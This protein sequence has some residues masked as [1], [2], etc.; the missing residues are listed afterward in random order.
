[1]TTGLHNLPAPNGARQKKKRLGR[2]RGSGLGKTAGRGHKGQKKTKSGNVRV[3]FEGGQLPLARRLPKVGFKNFDFKKTYAV[4]N[5]DRLG[6]VFA[7]GTTVDHA[8]FVAHG[9]AKTSELVKVLGTGEL[10]HKLN[11]KVHAISESARQKVEA[12][13][14]TVEIIST[15]KKPVGKA[16]KKAEKKKAG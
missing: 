16:A 13:G 15:E 6:K 5:L 4:V 11:L 3:G 10:P 8:A 14:G 2:G 7:A 12:K 1:M 9:F